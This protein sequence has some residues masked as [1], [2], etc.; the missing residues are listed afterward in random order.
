MNRFGRIADDLTEIVCDLETSAQAAI[1]AP[2]VRA[3]QRAFREACLADKVV[4]DNE[5]QPARSG[6]IIFLPLR[7]R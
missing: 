4:R 5:D 6:Q 1:A 3:L 2:L 7:S